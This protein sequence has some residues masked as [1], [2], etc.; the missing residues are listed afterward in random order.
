[1]WSVIIRSY[2]CEIHG[3]MNASSLHSGRT[4][5]PSYLSFLFSDYSFQ[6]QI[7]TFTKIFS[8]KF[9]GNKRPVSCFL[10]PLFFSPETSLIKVFP[11]LNHSS[12]DY[13]HET[14]Y[15]ITSLYCSQCQLWPFLTM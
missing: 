12:L 6:S 10:F 14:K 15:H 1:M 8:E 4:P 7:K 9:G 2:C 13:I 11:Y 5:V 3:N